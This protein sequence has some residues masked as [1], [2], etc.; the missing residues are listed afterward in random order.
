MPGSALP[1]AGHCGSSCCLRGARIRSGQ[2]PVGESCLDVASVCKQW[3]GGRPASVRAFCRIRMRRLEDWLMQ[4][5]FGRYINDPRP[6]C[7]SASPQSEDR[8]SHK[9]IPVATDWRTSAHDRTDGRTEGTRGRG[10]DLRSEQ[11]FFLY[12][13]LHHRSI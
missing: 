6:I 13:R 4:V 10:G 2:M 9:E 8:P 12:S 3:A 7:G 5:P 1:V 11:C